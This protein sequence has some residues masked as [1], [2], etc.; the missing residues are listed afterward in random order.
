[1]LVILALQ[2][3]SQEDHKLEASLNS[4]E[5]LWRKGWREGGRMHLENTFHSSLVF[6]YATFFQQRTIFQIVITHTITTFSLSHFLIP[7]PPQFPWQRISFSALATYKVEPLEFMSMHS[8]FL[9]IHF[10]FPNH[11]HCSLSQL[12]VS[13]Q[14]QIW[15]FRYVC[16]SMPY[17]SN[18]WATLSRSILLP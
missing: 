7:S 2:R 13:F 8:D 1:M 10:K 12:S 4:I 15:T 5:K 3:K 6:I 17:G 14:L 11:L 16:T 18:K 9:T